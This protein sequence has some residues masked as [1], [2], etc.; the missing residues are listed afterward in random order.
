M[1]PI[2]II[3]SPYLILDRI[4]RRYIINRLRS[5]SLFLARGV[6]LA[7]AMFIRR[8][9]SPDEEDCLRR[10]IQEYQVSKTE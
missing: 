9:A 3:I 7:L 8:P 2:I 5:D 6:L 1:H 4:A 10:T